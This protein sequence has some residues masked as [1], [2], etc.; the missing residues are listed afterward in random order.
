MVN[1][2]KQ[3][4]SKHLYGRDKSVNELLNDERINFLPDMPL[5]ETATITE[6]RVSKYSIIMIDSCQYSVPDTYVDKLLICKVYTKK[7]LVFDEEKIIAEHDK[8]VGFNKW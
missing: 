7:L 4:N 3:I 6:V 8:I 1:I 5:Y 2:L